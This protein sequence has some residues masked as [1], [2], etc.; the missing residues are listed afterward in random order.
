MT[1]CFLG[2]RSRRAAALGLLCAWASVVQ[3][4]RATAQQMV[5]DQ[6]GGGGGSVISDGNVNP[7]GCECGPQCSYGYGDYQC[8]GDG[9][10]CMQNDGCNQCDN[11]NCHSS[12]DGWINAEYLIWRLSGTNLPPLVTSTP[13]GATTPPNVN[14]GSL[15]DPNATVISGG[16]SV[17]G[18]W[19]S[20]FRLSGGFWLDCCHDCGLGFDYF[21][22]GNDDYN[23][24]SPQDPSII[25]SRPFF[26]TAAAAPDAQLVSVPG[27]LNGTT[28]IH[29][30]DDF[31]GAGATFNKSIWRCCDCCQSSNLSVIGGYRFYRFDS[32]LTVIENLTVIPPNGSGAAVL[33]TTINVQDSFRTRNDFNGGEIGLQCYKQRNCFWVDG[34]AKVGLGQNVRSV[35]INGQTITDVPGG[36][37]A[38]NQGG[39]LTSSATNIGH[40]RDTD[41]AV[42][43]EF[44]AGIGCCL[45]KC[46][47]VHAGYDCIIWPDVLRAAQTLPNNLAVDPANIPPVQPGG[48]AD[49]AFPG[50][51]GTQL[52][53]HGIDASIQ[54][55][56]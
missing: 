13:V 55:Q 41:F 42:I 3:A 33:G 1:S 30:G 11:G 18:D 39:L 47:S 17:N 28:S 12:C 45:T 38:T 51:H 32:D 19:R 25:T 44:K 52:V 50:F 26:N 16:D 24:T 22:L 20:G 48:G 56:W 23:F 6:Y 31:E 54:W 29:S 9:A 14:Q 46:C 34:M 35:T 10:G 27:G 43:P 5:S 2:S 36:G 49:P 4:N 15:A 40:Y 37:I 8:Y 53:A 21:N 7:A